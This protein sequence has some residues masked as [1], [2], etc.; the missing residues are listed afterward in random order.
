MLADD[1]DAAVSI[2]EEPHEKVERDEDERVEITLE[3]D[4]I[5]ENDLIEYYKDGPKNQCTL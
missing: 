3:Y 1:N 4:G 5:D 2:T